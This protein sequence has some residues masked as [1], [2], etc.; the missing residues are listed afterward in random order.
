MTNN[1][2]IRQLDP[3]QGLVDYVLDVKP[4]HTKIIEVMI[5]YVYNDDVTG[6]VS[7][8]I[9]FS[10]GPS[11]FQGQGTEGAS[12]YYYLPGDFTQAINVAGSPNVDFVVFVSSAGVVSNPYAV[13][14]VAYD[15][16]ENE[17]EITIDSNVPVDSTHI[18]IMGDLQEPIVNR[19]DI[20][21]YFSFDVLEFD[22]VQQ[23]ITVSGPATA[24][25]F[26]G[27]QIRIQGSI[28]N[29]GL[30][31]VQGSPTFNGLSTIIPVAE[32]LATETIGSPVPSLRPNRFYIP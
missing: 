11:K 30:Y 31:T 25:I 20:V 4:Y 27:Q 18:M 21:T 19:G 6:V 14:N 17:T 28:S 2:Y 24:N 23:T 9:E 15:N 26:N 22:E 16:I 8:A 7:D 1:A 5:E 10:W 32:T 3:I 29:D 13:I 12:P